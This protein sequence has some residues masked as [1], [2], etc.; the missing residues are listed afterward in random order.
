MHSN[1]DRTFFLFQEK[2]LLAVAGKVVKGGL[3]VQMNCP[4]TDEPTQVRRSSPVPC[5]TGGS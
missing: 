1:K 3:P 5:V 4:D 2:N